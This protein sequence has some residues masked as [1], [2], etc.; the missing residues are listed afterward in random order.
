MGGLSA[1]HQFTRIGAH[2]MIAGVTGLRSDV[3]PFGLAIGSIGRLAGLNFVGM[4]RRAFSRETRHAVRK[5]Y[6]MLFFGGGL[7]AERLD[8]VAAELGGDTAVAQIV[9]FV[10]AGHNRAL[11]QPGEHH[12]D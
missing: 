4:K 12:Q 11:C 2:A 1:A 3:I 6:Y 8:R 5:A 7:F 9:E 10:R